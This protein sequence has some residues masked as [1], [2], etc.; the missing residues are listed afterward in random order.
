MSD[1]AGRGVRQKAREARLKKSPGMGRKGAGRGDGVSETGQAARAVG[2]VS[3]PGERKR[4][5]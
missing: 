5:A 2:L 3:Q 4:G 1:G